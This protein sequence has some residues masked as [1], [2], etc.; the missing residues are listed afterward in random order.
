M[1]SSIKH[2]RT[3]GMF[4]KLSFLDADTTL[5]VACAWMALNGLAGYFAT[6]KWIEGW[7]GSALSATE[8]GMGKLFASTMVGSAV[9]LYAKVFA[10]KSALESYG[11]M[12]AAYA[13]SSLD[14][15]FVSKTMDAMGVDKNKALFWA[16]LQLLTFGAIF[17]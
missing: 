12:M 11:L 10:D 15:S 5:K 2:L 16:A 4:G 3:V 9:Y 14:G 8:A 17:Y 6:D 1:Y 7:G 13:A